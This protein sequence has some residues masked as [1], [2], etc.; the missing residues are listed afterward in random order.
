MG[1]KNTFI[2]L[3]L[4]EVNYVLILAHL[5]YLALIMCWSMVLDLFSSLFVENQVSPLFLQ[6]LHFFEK[7]LL[8]TYSTN[9]CRYKTLWSYI[10]SGFQRV[11]GC[12]LHW[13]GLFHW[14]SFAILDCQTSYSHWLKH[15]L[16]I[17]FWT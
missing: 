3:A 2:I 14:F 15:T 10:L 16:I 6:F 8:A 9:S 17:Y 5:A 4:F 1:T 7:T 12:N 11:F 13:I